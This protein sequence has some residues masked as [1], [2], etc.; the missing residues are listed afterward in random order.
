MEPGR[1]RQGAGLHFPPVLGQN[2]N[3]F[4]SKEEP[5]KG[6]TFLGTHMAQ[7]TSKTPDAWAEKKNYAYRYRPLCQ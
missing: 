5:N 7:G 3:L 6:L 1:L 4:G 2:F